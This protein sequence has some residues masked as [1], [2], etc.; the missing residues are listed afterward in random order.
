MAT[1]TLKQS[2]KNLKKTKDQTQFVV[3]RVNRNFPLIER[4]RDSFGVTHPYRMEFKT[5][6]ANDL[7]HVTFIFAELFEYEC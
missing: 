4:L 1:D 5:Y 2:S 3:N 6:E 7:V